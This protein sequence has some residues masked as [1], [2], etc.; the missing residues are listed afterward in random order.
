M[1]LGESSISHN[2]LSMQN[3]QSLSAEAKKRKRNRITEMESSQ[4]RIS[5]ILSIGQVGHSAEGI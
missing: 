4:R 3:I 1:Y 2:G 5:N